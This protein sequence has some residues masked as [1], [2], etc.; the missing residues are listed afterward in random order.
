MIVLFINCVTF[1]L[2]VFM[3]L[4]KILYHDQG[5]EIVGIGRIVY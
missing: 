2:I 3:L 4:N 5:K 1:Y